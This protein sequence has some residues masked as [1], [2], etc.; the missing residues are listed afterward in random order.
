MDRLTRAGHLAPPFSLS[1]SLSS[2]LVV[3]G[4]A[5]GRR[6]GGS[7]RRI[8]VVKFLTTIFVS[9]ADTETRHEPSLVFGVATSFVCGRTVLCTK[10]AV[11]RRLQIEMIPCVCM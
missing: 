11:N 7:V 6:T 9:V 4:E 5:G 10:T 2:L 3:E 8:C 1:V